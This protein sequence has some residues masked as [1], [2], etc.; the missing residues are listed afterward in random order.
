MK[1]IRFMSIKEFKLYEKG[2]VIKPINNNMNNK[3]NTM[4]KNMVC[5]APV[6]DYNYIEGLFFPEDEKVL[7]IFE[8]NEKLI[9][10]GIGYYFD[11]ERKECYMDSYSKD[12][13]KKIW[14]SNTIY[15]SDL[16]MKFEMRN[17]KKFLE[18]VKY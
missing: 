17:M 14:V 7:V 11:K 8:V 13:A 1:I 9:T 5:F 12:T 18:E 15:G 6:D 10:S 3:L 16:I 4:T 2:E